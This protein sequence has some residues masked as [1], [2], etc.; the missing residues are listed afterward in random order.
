MCSPELPRKGVKPNQKSANNRRD[1]VLVSQLLSQP[2]YTVHC[3]TRVVQTSSNDPSEC[4]KHLR[5]AS[6]EE[7][8]K[9]KEVSRRCK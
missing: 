4:Q 8:E 6:D 5:N 3:Y 1:S 7:V 2:E 9:G